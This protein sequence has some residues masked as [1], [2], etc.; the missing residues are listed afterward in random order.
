M[1]DPYAYD[2][3][4]P[5]N[6][7]GIKDPQELS[8]VE[9][10]ICSSK[11]KEI[12]SLEEPTLQNIHKYIFEDIFEWAGEYRI[13]QIH[14]EEEILPGYCTRFSKPED[15]SNDL[16]ELIN[17][18]R[19]IDW[20]SMDIND[21]CVKYAI[22]MAKI[23]RVHPFRDG[24]TRTTVAYAYRLAKE[25]GFPFDMDT[26]TQE[27]NRVYMGD[28]IIGYSVRDKFTLASL[29]EEDFPE[30]EYLAQLFKDAYVAYKNKKYGV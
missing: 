26:I 29:D 23:W 5:I 3:G 7:L 20:L 21:M 6:K 30:P 12:D 28:Y 24:N 4:V 27:L 14:K 17:G 1:T 15:I 2:N 25:L 10:E 8:E 16:E 19:S 9:K 18:I 13:V 11:L 22:E